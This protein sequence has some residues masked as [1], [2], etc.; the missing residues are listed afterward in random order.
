MPTELP[1]KDEDQIPEGRARSQYPQ[2]TSGEPAS[3]PSVNGPRQEPPP[4]YDG[5]S[6]RL[7]TVAGIPIRIHLTFLLLLVWLA[8]LSMPNGHGQVWTSLGFVLAIFGCVLLH[9]LSHAMVARRYGVQTRSITLYPIG[10]VASL[11]SPPR[12]RQELWIALAGP[13]MNLLIAGLIA[14]GLVAARMPLGKFHLGAT[15]NGFAADL[16]WA[17]LLLAGFNML[18]AFPMDGGRVLRSLIARFT[19]E[20]QATEIAARIGQLFALLFGLFGLFIGD[21][22]LILVAAFVFFGAGQEAHAFQTRTLM[23]GHRVREA[24]QREFRVLPVGYTLQEAADALLA[25]SQHDFPVV[26]GDEVVGL[27]SRSALMRGMATEGP[28][29]YVAGVMERDFPHVRPDDD[30]EQVI[31]QFPQAGP[32]LVMEEGRQ[33]REALIG[34]LTQEHL[35]EFLMLSQ[36]RTRPPDSFRRL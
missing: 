20:S 11:D 21:F 36:L 3:Q 7:I 24:M 12:P 28:S 27:L 18:P 29:G 9:E 32:I 13:A 23:M 10:G 15:T 33:D 34:M 8:F 22:L 19:D 17:N 16:F 4:G 25:G 5:A 6:F 26:H 31:A 1:Q 30:L 2:G 35:F 14:L